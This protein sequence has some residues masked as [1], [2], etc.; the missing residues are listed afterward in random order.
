[1]IGQTISHYRILEKLGGGGMGVVYK[2]EDLNLR[3]AVALKFLPKEL[4][5]DAQSLERFRHE[6]RSASALNHPNIVTVHEIANSEAGSFL[7]MEWIQG[8]TLRKRMERGLDLSS[9][10]QYGIQVARALRT[11]HEAGIIHRDIKPENIMVRPDGYVKLVDFGLALVTTLAPGSE[12]RSLRLTQGGTLLGTLA[13]FSPEQARTEMLQSG[14]D[15]FSLGLVLYEAAAGRHPF[16]A[17]S[18]FAIVNGIVTQNPLTPSRLNPEI[19]HTLE[20]LIL[21]MLEKDARLRPSAGEVEQVLASLG[22]AKPGGEALI[23]RAVDRKTVG[24]GQELAELQTAYGAAAAG[25]S[26][27]ICVTGEAGIGKSTLVEEFVGELNSTVHPGSV[28]HGR[29]SERLGS[30]EAYLPFL[31]ALYRQEPAQLARA[32][33]HRLS[34]QSPTASSAAHQ[35]RLHPRRRRF[36]KNQSSSAGDIATRLR[37]ALRRS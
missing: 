19:P 27:L 5:R 4:A 36:S 18:Q 37:T 31:E 21:A 30:N 2:A 23:L 26:S 17:S 1:M 28:A 16:A 13:Y 24:R 11:A 29:C 6:A 12:T 25:R 8:E 9:L 15:I 10:A 3:R 7:V 14:S 20:Q 34:S 22:G 33:A 32:P 35:P